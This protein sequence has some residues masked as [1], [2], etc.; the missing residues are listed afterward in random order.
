MKNPVLKVE[1][2]NAGYRDNVVLR[3]ASFELY[4]GSLVVLIGANGSGKSTLL[5]TVSGISAPLSGRVLLSGR[6][7]GSYSRRALARELS[8][9]FTDRSGGGDLTVR[10]C[11]SMGRYAYSGPF[12][13][14]DADDRACVAEA[15]AAVGLSHKADRHLGT[16]SDGERQKAMI[17]R[18]LAQQ[19]PLIILDEPT[20]F[21]D[22]AGRQEII[23]L[24]R[25]LADGGRTIIISTHDIAPAIAAADTIL[26][27]DPA[28]HR[29]LCGP[30][31]GMIAS[32]V[33]DR[34]FV[35]LR[36]DPVKGDF[37]SADDRSC[38]GDC[39]PCA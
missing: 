10:E 17:A 11:V 20:A 38:A 32:G 2:L 9:V 31:E 34:A 27:A 12:S 30:K 33:L 14:P 39:G 25:S 26:M 18:A 22:V 7:V 1:N 13:R 28:E 21:L 37:V 24:L 8:V 16:L 15:I 3:D 19:T 29:L 6:E 23:R 35:N 4:S 36:F 5:R